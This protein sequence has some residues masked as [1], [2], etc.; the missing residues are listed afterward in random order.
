MEIQIVDLKISK[1]QK[2]EICLSFGVAS[3]S[4]NVESSG[5]L[6][7]N[8][9]K[10]IVHAKGVPSESTNNHH[11]FDDGLTCHMDEITHRIEFI[12]TALKGETSGLLLVPGILL[13]AEIIS[14]EQMRLMHAVIGE[15]YLVKNKSINTSHEADYEF[16]RS[17]SRKYYDRK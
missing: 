1:N 16:L 2:D 4:E 15:S 11:I 14:E 5:E 9:L 8:V 6:A 13:S 12:D 10:E 3:T 7:T 17:T